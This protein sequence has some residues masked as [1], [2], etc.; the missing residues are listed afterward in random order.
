M[1]GVEAEGAAGIG[2]VKRAV[3]QSEYVQIKVA[4][5]ALARR[6]LW[7]APS[8]A[9]DADGVDLEP[10]KPRHPLGAAGQG[11]PDGAN[12]S[13]APARRAAHPAATPLVRHELGV[14]E[15]MLSGEL[16][17]EPLGLLDEISIV[18]S[19]SQWEEG[20]SCGLFGR[21]NRHVTSPVVHGRQASHFCARCLQVPA[22][23]NAWQP[24]PGAGKRARPAWMT[25]PAPAAGDAS[26]GCA[27]GVAGATTEQA[28]LPGQGVTREAVATHLAACGGATAHGLAR[29]FGCGAHTLHRY[30]LLMPAAH[31]PV[32][33]SR[34]GARSICLSKGV[35]EPEP[36]CLHVSCPTTASSSTGMTLASC[37]VRGM[38]FG[39]C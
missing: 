16:F 20:S 15:I 8:R 34:M 19:T 33:C 22:D 9:A 38:C 23:I 14:Q 5:A 27:G 37:A 35:S 24:A 2:A 18:A 11:S 7:F 36:R 30:A 21:L 39:P 1:A 13:G 31:A 29:H 12:L 10:S 4:A 6:A 25:G 17:Q 3:P 32:L 28:R 26:G